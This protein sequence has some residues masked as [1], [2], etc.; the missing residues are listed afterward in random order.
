MCPVRK[1]FQFYFPVLKMRNRKDKKSIS[2]LVLF[3]SGVIFFILMLSLYY[4]K[5]LLPHPAYE[6]EKILS[7]GVQQGNDLDFR[8]ALRKYNINFES[9]NQAT[10]SSTLIVKL[11]KNSYVYFNLSK[12]SVSQAKIL[13][14]VLR[15]SLIE[16]PDKKLKYIDLRFDKAVVKFY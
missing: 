2:Y 15:R 16:N 10:L 1:S 5:N 4:F 11:D 8:K 7:P 12:D 3:F 6:S 13:S 14:E 9:I